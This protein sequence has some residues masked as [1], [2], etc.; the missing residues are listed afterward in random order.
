MLVTVSG[1]EFDESLA[2]A[3][4]L[5]LTDGLRP[6]HFKAALLGR[7][8]GICGEVAALRMLVALGVEAAWTGRDDWRAT[9][10]TTRD[11][12]WTIDVKTSS[13]EA[14][15]RYGIIIHCDH[16]PIV[17][18]RSEVILWMVADVPQY[19]PEIEVGRMSSIDIR[20]VGWIRSDEANRFQRQNAGQGNRENY[21]IYRPYLSPIDALANK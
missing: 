11:P 18:R 8:I 13:R 19:M 12:R 10:I 4:S 9:D 20:D 5:I 14:I 17:R 6:G 3:E 1:E 15:D 2:R 16:L 21:R 7:L